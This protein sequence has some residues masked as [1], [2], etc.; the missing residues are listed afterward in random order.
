MLFDEKKKKR[1]SVQTTMFFDRKYG[2]LY[3]KNKREELSATKGI[4]Y[5]VM[6]FLKFCLWQKINVVSV[7]EI[8][9]DLFFV[10]IE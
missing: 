7:I 2:I 3:L 1:K 4:D 5:F 10:G 8:I 6:D 9:F